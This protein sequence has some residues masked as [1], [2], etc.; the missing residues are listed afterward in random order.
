[1]DRDLDLHPLRI[2]DEL[3][4][5]LDAVVW[6]ATI[7][8]LRFT[9]VSERSQGMLGYPPERWFEE[10]FWERHVHPDDL[11]ALVERCEA[12]V[13]RGEDLT[14]EY[15]FVAADD[16]VLWLRSNIRV[17]VDEQGRPERMRGFI[18]DITAER[19]ETARV[20]RAEQL[21]A[22]AFAGSPV[23]MNMWA[24]DEQGRFVEVNDAFCELTG[25]SRE[26][27]LQMSYAPLIAPEHLPLARR[28]NR[29]VFTSADGRV[30]DLEFQIVRA[31]GSRRWVAAT[32]SVVRDAMGQAIHGLAHVVDITDRRASHEEHAFANAVV[33]SVAEGIYAVDADGVITFVNPAAEAMLGYDAGEL[34]GTD[35]HAAIHF[36]DEHGAPVPAH[37]CPLL[38]VR[39][40]GAQ[41]SIA[42]DTYTCK[43]GRRIPVSLSS[44]PLPQADGRRGAVIAFRDIS[45][46]KAA[47][48]R[49]AGQLE[50]LRWLGRIRAALAEDRFVL[51]AQPIVDLATG[52]TVSDELL[53]RMIGEDGDLIPPGAFLPTAEEHGLI[54]EIDCWVIARAAEIAAAG[55]PVQVNL[56]ARSLAHRHVLDTIAAELTR[57]GAD[58]QHLI[59][60]LTETAFVEDRAGSVA[61]VNA[62]TAMGCQLALD[63]FGTGY[64]TF[65]YLKDLDV[66]HLK[67]D[68]EFVRE[69]HDN[70][71]CRHVVAAVVS[72]AAGLDLTTV[73]EGV[74][75]EATA[76]LLQELGVQHAQGYLFARPAPLD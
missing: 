21:F 73:A 33:A 20:Q 59:F 14:V 72:L 25:Y 18:V 67:I 64:G 63:D 48:Q 32:T 52:R 55:R 13:A 49:I 56:S 43:D 51:Y 19:G 30:A 69:L 27:L 15:R 24:G 29:H 16:R 6:E 5:S 57:T 61:F 26:Q 60:E 37:A 4:H 65:T 1:M 75:D 71:S 34:L 45:E 50:S 28:A 74:E 47:E 62:L 39:L 40:S 8:P 7:E 53:I 66:S 58:P 3:L 23:P 44:S 35:A 31:D 9:F 12:S 38:E 42:S 70:P 10:R 76:A 36:Q 22:L 41:I 17:L 68:R 11:D 2:G 46:R 54:V